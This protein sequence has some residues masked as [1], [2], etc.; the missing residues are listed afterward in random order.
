MASGFLDPNFRVS[1]L[2]RY[3]DYRTNMSY[4]NVHH[5]FLGALKRDFLVKYD[6]YENMSD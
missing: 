3:M 4:S 6:Q 5:D 2:E 1:W